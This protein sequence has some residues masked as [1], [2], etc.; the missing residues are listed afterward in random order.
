M[1][2]GFGGGGHE[3]G[4]AAPAGDEVDVEMLVDAGAGSGAE[5]DADVEAVGAEGGVDGGLEA[6]EHSHHLEGFVVG[7]VLQ[8]AGLAVGQDHEVAG[9]VGINIE[10]GEAALAAGEDEVGFVVGAL[11]DAGEDVSLVFLAIFHVKIA[12]RR[13]EMFHGV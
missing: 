6:L 3:V 9:V 1:D 5:V 11:R 13:P 8:P 10:Q 7:E 4:V 12:P 2:A